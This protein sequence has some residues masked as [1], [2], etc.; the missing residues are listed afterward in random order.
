M[1]MSWS[2]FIRRTEDFANID[3]KGRYFDNFREFTGDL[4][5]SPNCHASDHI[6]VIFISQKSAKPRLLRPTRRV[7]F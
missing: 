5:P 2:F 7:K 4:R 3:L 1:A 6:A